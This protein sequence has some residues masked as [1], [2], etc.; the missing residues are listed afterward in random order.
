MIIPYEKGNYDE[1]YNLINI[2][3]FNSFI[4]QSQSNNTPVFL[5]TKDQVQKDG[6]VWKNMKKN[7]DDFNETFNCLADRII[8]ATK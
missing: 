7:I 4:A 2:A 8:K 3:D 5:L 6:N 1:G